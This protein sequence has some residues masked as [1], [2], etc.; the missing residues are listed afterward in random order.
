MDKFD[1]KIQQLR[2]GANVKKILYPKLIKDI[3]HLVQKGEPILGTGLQQTNSR[4][5]ESRRR[6]T[7]ISS[8]RIKHI[9]R[10]DPFS[11][12][13]TKKLKRRLKHLIDPELYPR[14]K[15]KFKDYF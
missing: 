2:K 8:K 9:Y 5:D 13:S 1:G 10:V 3:E 4:V 14:E 6:T 12:E 11:L 15:Y 7:F